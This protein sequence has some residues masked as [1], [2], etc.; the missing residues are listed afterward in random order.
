MGIMPF[1]L[2]S[3]S[4]TNTQMHNAATYLRLKRNN[5][6]APRKTLAE[7]GLLAKIGL[8]IY[9]LILFFLIRELRK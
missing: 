4:S 9:L 8:L 6:K 1:I 2:N 5:Y 3:M 7:T